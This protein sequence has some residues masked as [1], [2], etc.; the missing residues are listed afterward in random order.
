MLVEIPEGKFTINV[1][2][3]DKVRG[4][5]NAAYNPIKVWRGM[6]PIDPRWS[7]NDGYDATWIIWVVLC[8]VAVAVVIVIVYF[9]HK[10]RGY[11]KLDELLVN[12]KHQTYVPQVPVENKENGL[13]D[14]AH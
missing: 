6:K 3:V 2:T 8:V 7:G 12:K 5:N 13:E 11:K 4:G 1:V 9:I 14:S 10:K